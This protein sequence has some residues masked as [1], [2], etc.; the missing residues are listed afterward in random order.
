MFLIFSISRFK[1]LKDYIDISIKKKKK[2][3]HIQFH[4]QREI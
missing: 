2:I 3:G 1:Y 4:E